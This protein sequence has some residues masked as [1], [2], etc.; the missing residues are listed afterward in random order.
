MRIRAAMHSGASK[1]ESIAT[2]EPAECLVYKIFKLVQRGARFHKNDMG[3]EKA[4]CSKILMM[5]VKV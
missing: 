4:I 1:Y 5:R 2:R 3:E